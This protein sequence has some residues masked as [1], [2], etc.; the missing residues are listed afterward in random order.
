MAMEAEQER[1]AEKAAI[2][3]NPIYYMMVANS[4]NARQVIW[5]RMNAS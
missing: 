3:P 4:A 1:E 5:E 2:W